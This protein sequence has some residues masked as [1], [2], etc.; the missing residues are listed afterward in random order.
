MLAA[1]DNA[2]IA[3][4]LSFEQYQ[5]VLVSYT[6]VLEAQKRSFAAQTTL[7]TIK[8][9]LIAN[10]INLHFSLGGDFTT[11]SLEKEAK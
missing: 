8:N 3:S 5:S 4:T 7:I 10:R 1:Q 9:Q 2:K 11:P 6:T